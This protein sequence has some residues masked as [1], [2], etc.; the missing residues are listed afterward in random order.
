MSKSPPL[1]QHQKRDDTWHRISIAPFDCDLQ[2]AVIG[3]DGI[4]ALI[5]P[6]RR[7]RDGWLNAKTDETLDD[8]HPTHWRKWKPEYRTL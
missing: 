3:H 4:T 2:L 5:F 1:T 8:L 6:C 7:I